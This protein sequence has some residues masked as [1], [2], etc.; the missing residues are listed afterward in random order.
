MDFEKKYLKYKPTLFD[1]CL[2]FA[3]YNNIDEILNKYLIISSKYYYHYKN[4]KNIE[5]YSIRLF[6]FR[7][8]ID[9]K[10]KIKITYFYCKIIEE[11]IYS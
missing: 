5:V 4:I 1:L 10:I 3:V 2:K 11:K 7:D 9:L 8:N 6:E